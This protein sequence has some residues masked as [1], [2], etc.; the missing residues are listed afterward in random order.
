MGKNKEQSPGLMIAAVILGI[1]CVLT[2]I[3]L[4]LSLIISPGK[5]D[6]VDLKA[7][8]DFVDN[9]ETYYNLDRVTEYSSTAAVV[10]G[11]ATTGNVDTD[12]GLYTGFVFPNS[13]TELITQEMMAATLT[14]ASLCRR[15]INE[16]Y[17]R[18]GY[19]FTKQ[20]NLD[21]FNQYDWYK[22]MAK[23]SNMSVVSAGFSTIEKKNVESL[24]SYENAKG[25]G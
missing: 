21:Y 6:T 1:V 4:V 19:L 8:T 7:Q 23:E 12:E 10:Y 18:H 13:D 9:S 25:W 15:A 14:D 20:E 2:L 3:S 24:Q 5:G 17:A 22:N 11:G 16:I